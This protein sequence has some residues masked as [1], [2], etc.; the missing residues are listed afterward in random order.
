MTKA[1]IGT[2]PACGGQNAQLLEPQFQGLVDNGQVLLT[3]MACQ[4][5]V[6]GKISRHIDADSSL[7][8]DA[9][10]TAKA[11]AM[12]KPQAESEPAAKPAETKAPV[13]NGK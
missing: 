2:C 5:S 10:K 13:T 6:I 12:S 3:C 7:S 8:A 9:K 4:Q 1:V 11:K